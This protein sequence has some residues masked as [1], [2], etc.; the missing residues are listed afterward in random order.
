MQRNKSD[1]DALPRIDHS[2]RFGRTIVRERSLATPSTP[3]TE[4]RTRSERSRRLDTAGSLRNAGRSGG[5]V[6]QGSLVQKSKGS[7]EAEQRSVV[8]TATQT[9]LV[10]RNFR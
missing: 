9:L 8:V 7:I 2:K 1:T 6:S 5:N 3:G 10:V 4:K